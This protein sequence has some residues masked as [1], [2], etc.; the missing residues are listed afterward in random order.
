MGFWAAQLIYYGYQYEGTAVPRMAVG[1]VE[2]VVTELFPRKIS[3]I[4][5]DKP[6]TRSRNLWPSGTTLTVAAISVA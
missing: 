3:L 5:P 4:S 6:T 1:E 2:T